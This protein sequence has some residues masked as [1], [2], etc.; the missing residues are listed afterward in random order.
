MEW[1]IFGSVICFGSY[2][3][4]MSLEQRYNG[5]PTTLKGDG[6]IV[7]DAT[8]VTSKQAVKDLVRNT[9][10]P[11][12]MLLDYVYTISGCSLSTFHRDV[13]SSQRGWNTEYPTYT[14]IHYL[15]GG[16]MLSVCR[17]SHTDYP[18]TW[19]RPENITGPA[20]RIVLFNADLLHAGM[21]NTI[22]ARRHAIQYKIAH[23]Q[24]IHSGVISHLEGVHMTKTETSTQNRF[25][26]WI[27]RKL[28][29][30]GSWVTNTVC[31]SLLTQKYRHGLASLLQRMIPLQF[32]NR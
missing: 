7:H 23:R 30:H 14:A 19:S 31:R 20:D 6:F 1:Y 9:L 3:Y 5:K 25:T 12:Y 32:Y 2:I 26:E 10:G 22:G 13:T 4:Y 15:T 18:F 8:V 29:Y 11:D 24:D 28:S 16:D 17:K 21:P 27:L